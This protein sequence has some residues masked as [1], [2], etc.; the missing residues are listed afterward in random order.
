MLFF[1]EDEIFFDPSFFPSH[2]QFIITPPTL[3]TEHVKVL[4]LLSA[5]TAAPARGPQGRFG[6]LGTLA[7]CAAGSGRLEAR[8]AAGWPTVHRPAPEQELS[9]PRCQDCQ[10]W[11]IPVRSPRR[12]PL[13]PGPL[14][15]LLEGGCFCSSSLPLK[16]TQISAWPN[17][18]FWNINEILHPCVKLLSHLQ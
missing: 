15:V 10:G 16:S 11:E 8:D 7:A 2:I 13:S 3:A 14:A 6:P 4:S 1:C 5:H 9:S 17:R 12:H 18:S